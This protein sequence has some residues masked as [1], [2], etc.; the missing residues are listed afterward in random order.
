MQTILGANGIIARGL[1]RRLA[2]YVDRIRQVS[3]S[4]RRVNPR[5]THDG[6]CASQSQ[7]ETALDRQS[8]GHSHVDLH[9]GRR[10]NPSLL[11]N[12]ASAYGQVWHAL[13][14][15]EP[16]TGEQFVRIACEISGRRC[17]LR[18]A[19][20]WM[21]SLL[22]II[23][24]IV[25]ENVEMLYQFEYDYRFDSSKLERAF[26]LAATSYREGI[27]AMLGNATT[28]DGHA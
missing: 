16:I 5:D 23:S 1:S 19:P 2:P 22:G 3:R 4:P 17:S 7:Q 14:S 15:H 20:G 28:T 9:A 8:E 27:A 11:G 21:L 25:R 13:T 10:A 12:T 18:A 6:D 24:P 26:S